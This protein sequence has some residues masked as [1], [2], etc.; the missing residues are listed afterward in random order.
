MSSPISL[1]SSGQ[2]KRKSSETTAE[3]KLYSILNPAVEA[4]KKTTLRDDL[5]Q[6]KLDVEKS[7][8]MLEKKSELSLKLGN[9]GTSIK[10]TTR[11]TAVTKQSEPSAQDRSSTSNSLRKMSSD[12]TR[13]RPRSFM[14]PS[15]TINDFHMLKQIGK[16]KFGDVH[17]AM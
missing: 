15:I 14:V 5:Y 7:K 12:R 1:P 9:S 6:L 11:I 2:L 3:N 8:Q 16:G 13:S 4:K 10:K 17:M